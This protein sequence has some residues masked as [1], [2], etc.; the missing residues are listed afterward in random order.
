MK[1][2][3]IDQI[4]KEIHKEEKEKYLELQHGWMTDTLQTAIEHT[5]ICALAALDRMGMS[6]EQQK[7]FFKEII[8]VYNCPPFFG[9]AVKAE[10]VKKRYE[11][12]LG[13]SFKDIKTT[14]ETK[15]EFVKKYMKG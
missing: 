9:K 5:T 14:F 11:E 10:D 15:E 12:K 7:E 13:I 8:F 2:K 4:R 1:V 3:T 6:E